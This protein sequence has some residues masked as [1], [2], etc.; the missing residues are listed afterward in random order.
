MGISET[1][2]GDRPTPLRPYAVRFSRVW[3]VSMVLG[4]MAIS[5]LSAIAVA[6]ATQ[7]RHLAPSPPPAVLFVVSVL[8]V[9]VG[10]VRL[11][12][13]RRKGWTALVVGSSG[14]YFAST[15]PDGEPRRFAWDE[16]GTLVLFSRR[17]EF[18]HGMVKCIGV[19]LHPTATDSPER[20]L[21]LLGQTLAQVDL[22]L[23]VWEQLRKLDSGPSE[24]QLET[25]VSFHT[26]ARGWRLHRSRLIEAMQA[27]AAGVPIIEFTA[28]SYY[29]LV[30][31]RADQNKLREIL[32]DAQLRRWGW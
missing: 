12:R 14:I 6:R 2:K 13:A 5:A 9:V 17:T 3:P 19:R 8:V 18:L 10:A 30:G 25:A 31:W 11:V 32:D 20:H 23:H 16:V 24:S 4:G 21:A 27:H 22:E 29:D 15:V 7:G 1:A 26:E 28:D